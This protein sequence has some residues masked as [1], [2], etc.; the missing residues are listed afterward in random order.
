MVLLSQLLSSPS[1]RLHRPVCKTSRF[2]F[3]RTES[4]TAHSVGEGSSHSPSQARPLGGT[5]SGGCCLLISETTQPS[6]TSAT[7]IN[8]L[9]RPI[10]PHPLTCSPPGLV[11]LAP[12]VLTKPFRSQI[13]RIDRALSGPTP[14]AIRKLIL[15]ESLHVLVLTRLLVMATAAPGKPRHIPKGGEGAVLQHPGGPG[16]LDC[17]WGGGEGGSGGRHDQE[18]YCLSPS[19]QGP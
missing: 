17:D 8:L 13:R 19:Q 14:L 7:G 3:R 18:G 5:R 15:P 2:S 9:P 16:Q 1:M 10:D 12:P 4:P 11:L 6:R